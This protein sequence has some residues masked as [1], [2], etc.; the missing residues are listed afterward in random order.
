[1]VLPPRLTS[2][3]CRSSRG[4]SP[5]KKAP[6]RGDIFHPGDLEGFR[7]L[8]NHDLGLPPGLRQPSKLKGSHA[9][10][11]EAQDVV[12]LDDEGQPVNARPGYPPPP[13]PQ[14]GLA[15]H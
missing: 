1:M 12:W 7:D 2:D 4:P 5:T 11:P 13:P 10:Y 15:G 9:G 6:P 14:C 3:G 8:S